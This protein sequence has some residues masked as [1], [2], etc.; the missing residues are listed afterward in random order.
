VFG[1]LTFGL[2]FTTTGQEFLHSISRPA[3]DQAQQIENAP[4]QLLRVLEN[5]DTPL[6][7]LDAKVKEI[8]GAD[9]AKLTG[10]KTNLSMV[11]SVPE[12]RLINGS[13]K[14]I[15]GFVL[16]I[17]DPETK[18]S[19]GLVQSKT[20]ITSGE[21][22]V[23]PRQAFIRPEWISTVD[24]NGQIKPRFGSPEINSEKFWLSFAGRSNLF[25][26][27]AQVNFQDGSTWTLK[28]GGEIR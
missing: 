15:T 26:T 23:A 6:H 16:V 8:S 28:E 11:S 7:I 12:V 18:T 4:D 3:D 25:V 13:G 17:R 14:T 22:Y 24:K 21:T 10:K 20:S 9:F 1:V 2:G 19:R 5:S 27:V